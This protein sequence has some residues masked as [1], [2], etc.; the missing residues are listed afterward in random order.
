LWV[1]HK[2][3]LNSG[4]LKTDAK[5]STIFLLYIHVPYIFHCGSALSHVCFLI[6]ALSK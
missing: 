2:L 1:F 5:I 6:N 3:C 4:K